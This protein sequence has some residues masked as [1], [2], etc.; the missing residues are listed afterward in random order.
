MSG[1]DAAKRSSTA[2][3]G[4]W[5]AVVAGRY[6]LIALCAVLLMAVGIGP[7]SGVPESPWKVAAGLLVAPI[8]VAFGVFLVRGDGD[9]GVGA[10]RAGA[11][12]GVLLGVG[13]LAANYVL[14]VLPTMPVPESAA[15][16]DPSKFPFR[17]GEVRQYS[18]GDAHGTAHIGPDGSR[19][20]GPEGAATTTPRFRVGLIGDSFVFG[21]SIHDEDSLCWQLREHLGTVAP[22]VFEVHNYGQPGASVF[23]YVTML[24][25][26]VARD[27]LDLVLVG[28]LPMNDAEVWDVN[29]H[30]AV[31]DAWWFRAMAAATEPDMAV[32]LLYG[33][34]EV[35]RSELFDWA[36]MTQGMEDLAAASD[37]LGVQTR[38]FFW[39]RTNEVAWLQP[40]VD[41]SNATLAQS[42]TSRFVGMIG[43]SEDASTGPTAIPG[44]GHPTHIGIESAVKQLA[45]V[46]LD[47]R[48]EVAP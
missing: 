31:V 33:F 34:M 15:V 27:H 7:H 10:R 12:L 13:T 41:W 14:V 8:V 39:I 5:L 38:W 17:P 36:A 28:M 40:L 9:G 24:K 44:D 6:V 35:G 18:G 30:A 19:V 47:A 4:A 25:R 3:F 46:V 29:Q 16:R 26:A 48:G 43:L 42:K 32:N 45:P 20:C 22:D 37:A 21:Q 2:T 23:S 11:A 1:V